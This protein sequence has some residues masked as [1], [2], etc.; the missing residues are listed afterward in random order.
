MFFAFSAATAVFTRRMQ[1][2]LAMVVTLVLLLI[3][4]GLLT[5]AEAVQSMALL[6][7]GTVAAGAVLALAYRAGL[8]IINEI[9]PQEE[10]AEVVASFQIVHFIANS[11]P[12]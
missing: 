8:Q 11:L 3:G 12:V 10:R 2:R 4:L 7:V 1:A 5:A 6:L 9:A